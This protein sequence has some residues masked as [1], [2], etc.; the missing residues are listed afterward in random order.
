MNVAVMKTKAEAALG[1]QFEAVAERLPGAG[2]V[3]ELRKKAIGVF[4]TLGLPHRRIEEWKYTD[5]RERLR[6]AFPPAVV[7]TGAVSAA[8]LE[9]ALGHLAV[10][11]ADRLVFVDGTFRADL[12]CTDGLRDGVEFKTMAET[13]ETAPAWLQSKF[14]AKALT[15][16]DSVR[17]LNVAFMTDGVLLKVKPGVAPI[18]PAMLVFARPGAASNAVT[19]RNI[20]SVEAGAQLTLIE[21]HVALPGATARRQDNAVTDLTIGEAAA[22]TH[23]KCVADAGETTHL[24]T[25]IAK[26]GKDAAYNVFQLTAGASLARNQ[27]FATFTGEDAKLDASGV[28]LGRGSDHVDTTLVVDHAV[29]GCESRELFKGVLDGRARGVFQGKV[30]VRP[31]AQKTDGKQM[32]QVLM[33]SEDAEFDSKPEL[34]IHADDVVCGHGSTC[35][36]IDP[37]LLF[38]LQSRGLAKEEARTLLI[39]SFVAEA[40]DKIENE[41]VR[42]ALMGIARQW[43][44]AA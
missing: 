42:G 10:L 13:L 40:I 30:I 5:L 15:G 6:E 31:H 9:A 28:F 2:W 34:E 4:E 39:E 7:A 19:T 12:S 24:S 33:L 1:E 41:N 23:I 22:V 27:L 37:D 26:V 21:V 16:E 25:W 3:K 8:E 32:A 18:R 14:D 36:E 35:A 43:L 29:P 38:Y 11:H 20:I 44:A 17:A